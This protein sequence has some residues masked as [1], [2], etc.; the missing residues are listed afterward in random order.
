M[1]GDNKMSKE[2]WI[3]NL[4]NVSTAVA[5]N[6]GYEAVNFVLSKYGAACIEDLSESHYSTVFGE[7]YN[8]AQ[9]D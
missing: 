5:S 3:T 4:E 8:M 6:L 7:L 1:E 9:D 2:D